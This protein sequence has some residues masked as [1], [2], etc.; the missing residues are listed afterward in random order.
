MPTLPDGRYRTLFLSDLHLYAEGCRYDQINR[1]LKHK[2]F[3]SIYL[4]GDIVDFWQMKPR[5]LRAIRAPVD[6]SADFEKDGDANSSDSD[7]DPPHAPGS[8]KAIN[9]LRRILKRSQHDG[10]RILYLPG[11]HDDY[12]RNFTGLEMFGVGIANHALHT[13]A[14]GRRYLVLHGDIFDMVVRYHRQ[15]AVF[16]TIAY[17]YGERMNQM[18]N[19]LRRVFG[20]RPWSLAKAIKSRVDGAVGK[21]VDFEKEL[22]GA[23]RL[24]GVEGVICGH[25]HRPADHWH[26]DVRYLNCGDWV[27]H[28]TALVEHADGRIEMVLGDEESAASLPDTASRLNPEHRNPIPAL[29]P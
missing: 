27:E 17:N 2:H 7:N 6:D 1:F 25:S 18:V 5:T 8:E 15:L 14:D 9:I 10:T 28:G 21:A 13:A 4:V 16:S 22:V 3:E 19:R 26:G 20:L 11:N 23:A 24:R 12:F 29:H